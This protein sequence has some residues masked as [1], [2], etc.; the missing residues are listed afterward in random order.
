MY[1]KFLNHDL[2]MFPSE[3]EEKLDLTPW[4]RSGEKK[5]GLLVLILVVDRG[6]VL[7]LQ[8]CV[9]IIQVG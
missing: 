1:L 8:N 2:C 3:N 4:V 5:K 6:C 9:Q 7:G